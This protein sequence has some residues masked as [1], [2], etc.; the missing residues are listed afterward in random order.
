MRKK[1]LLVLGFIF[2]LNFLFVSPAEAATKR[3]PAYY[4]K[5]IAGLRAEIKALNKKVAKQEKE[6]IRLRKIHKVPKEIIKEQPVG[7]VKSP[8][9]PVVQPLSVVDSIICK[10][11]DWTKTGFN[12]KFNF[13]IDCFIPNLGEVDKRF[14]FTSVDFVLFVDGNKP[15]ATVDSVRVYENSNLEYEREDISFPVRQETTI[16]LPL[17]TRDGHV[18]NTVAVN[19]L[20]KDSVFRLRNLK[21]VNTE[22]GEE[23]T[24]F[25]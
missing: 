4:E 2:L 23:F 17:K 5:V 16:V 14:K 21:F 19:S 15:N 10:D 13:S 24:A 6:L 3:T 8:A 20:A 11:R 1:L 12:P 7:S 9:K 25:K 22:T 18:I